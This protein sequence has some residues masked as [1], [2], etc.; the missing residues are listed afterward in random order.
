MFDVLAD[1]GRDVR[2]EP[3]TPVA[4]TVV[5]VEFDI[6]TAVEYGRW[7]HGARYVRVR[8]DLRANDV[9]GAPDR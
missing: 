3:H 2:G 8:A 5:V 7:R 1:R 4:P 9:A 6:D